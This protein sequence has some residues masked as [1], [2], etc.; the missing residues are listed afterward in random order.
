MLVVGVQ[1]QNRTHHTRNA[2]P[3]PG[4]GPTRPIVPF[5]CT[6]TSHVVATP[7]CRR[8]TD[9]KQGKPEGSEQSRQ[10]DSG[11]RE[12]QAH[13]RDRQDQADRNATLGHTAQR[14]V[15]GRHLPGQID[16][17]GSG[18]M[19]WEMVRPEI[20][21]EACESVRSVAVSSSLRALIDRRLAVN[22]K[23]S[24]YC[25]ILCNILVIPL[26]YLP[27]CSG[28]GRRVLAEHAGPAFFGRGRKTENCLPLQPS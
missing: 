22:P 10:G 5:R 3:R 26:Y 8:G 2:S 19:R 24:L 11:D 12:P 15:Q 21:R 4:H 1:C 13:L 28:I 14:P 17:S 7:Q 6:D 16:R 27:R 25:T 18:T 9:R 20:R 23:G